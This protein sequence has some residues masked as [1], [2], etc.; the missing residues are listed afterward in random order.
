VIQLLDERT[1]GKTDNRKDDEGKNGGYGEINKIYLNISE[2]A[3]ST[4]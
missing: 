3:W 4:E 2:G 1:D